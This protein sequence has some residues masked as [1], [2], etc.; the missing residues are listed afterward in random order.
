M[1]MREECGAAGRCR[2]IDP[3]DDISTQRAHPRAG[4]QEVMFSV[5][6][7]VTCPTP[8]YVINSKI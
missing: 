3:E 2:A 1:A 4:S 6:V 8:G 7:L 5:S